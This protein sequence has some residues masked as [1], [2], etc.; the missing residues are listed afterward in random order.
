M[1]KSNT[2]WGSPAVAARKQHVDVRQHVDSDG[3][4]VVMVKDYNSFASIDWITNALAYV[5]L[6]RKPYCSRGFSEIAAFPS[7]IL[8]YVH[9][10]QGTLSLYDYPLTSATPQ[11][12]HK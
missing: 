5:T 1:R 2:H 12:V 4:N 6:F 10:L 7:D 8:D 11:L 9:M 3:L